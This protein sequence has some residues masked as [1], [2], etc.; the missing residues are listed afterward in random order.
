MFISVGS[1]LPE[2]DNL[3]PVFLPS[4]KRDSN[5]DPLPGPV[6]IT[7][8]KAVIRPVEARRPGCDRQVAD[9]GPAWYGGQTDRRWQ[10]K[11]PRTSDDAVPQD[12]QRGN[13]D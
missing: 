11:T 8:K 10:W 1:P 9:P 4:V 6:A 2:C 7:T 3:S 13:Q 5:V 12:R